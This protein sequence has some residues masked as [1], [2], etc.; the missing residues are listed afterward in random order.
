[1]YP[2]FSTEYYLT[3]DANTAIQKKLAEGFFIMNLWYVGD[4][5]YVTYGSKG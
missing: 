4:Q 5:T 3:S 1:M 2:N